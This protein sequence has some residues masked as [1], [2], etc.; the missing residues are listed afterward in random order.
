MKALKLKTNIHFRNLEGINCFW[1][2]IDIYEWDMNKKKNQKIA[3]ID[4][5]LG[6]LRESIIGKLDLR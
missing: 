5:K 6:Q 4:A 3:L 1:M 2:E